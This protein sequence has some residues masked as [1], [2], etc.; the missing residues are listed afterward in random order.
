MKFEEINVP[1]GIVQQID[2]KG[3]FAGIMVDERN[4]EIG[5]TMES[6]FVSRWVS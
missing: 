3:P 1:E 5:K 4:A 2:Q 6:V